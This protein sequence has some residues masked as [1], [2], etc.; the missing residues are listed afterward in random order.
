MEHKLYQKNVLENQFTMRKELLN[1]HLLL[2]VP[3]IMFLCLSSNTHLL[4][5]NST[6]LKGAK[7]SDTHLSTLLKYV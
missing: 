4:G 7:C 1:S 5:S 6:E 2:L 3:L